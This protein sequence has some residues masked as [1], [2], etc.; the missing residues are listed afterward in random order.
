MGDGQSCSNSGSDSAGSRFLLTVPKMFT[1]DSLRFNLEQGFYGNPVKSLPPLIN[2]DTENNFEALPGKSLDIGQPVMSGQTR[3]F[4]GKS[5]TASLTD[6]SNPNVPRQRN[7]NENVQYRPLDRKNDQGGP[8]MLDLGKTEAL[9]SS[10][11]SQATVV[12][13]WETFDSLKDPRMPS[14]PSLSPANFPF[15]CKLSPLS[16]TRHM[17]LQHPPPSLQS[18]PPSTTEQALSDNEE[19]DLTFS[20]GIREAIVVPSKSPTI[21]PERAKNNKLFP[22]STPQSEHFLSRRYRENPNT[23]SSHVEKTDRRRKPRVKPVSLKQP[24]K[25]AVEITSIPSSEMS[26]T[27]G[28]AEKFRSNCMIMSDLNSVS[29]RKTK[30]KRCGD[31][32]GCMKKDSCGKCAPCTNNKCHQVCKMRRCAKISEKK[33]KVCTF[34]SCIISRFRRFIFH[35]SNKP[36]ISRTK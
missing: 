22:L 33:P 7:Q 14:F 17:L 25:T 29:R 4:Y 28:P 15:S 2:L 21:L 34:S 30:R 11:P 16:R 5:P 10:E 23:T 19:K 36:S 12:K 31:C 20:S 13:F 35:I 9:P 18:A 1:H 6:L 8:I 3:D 32:A 24:G 27:Y 26:R